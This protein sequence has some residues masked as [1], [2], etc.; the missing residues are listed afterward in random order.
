[1]CRISLTVGVLVGLTVTSSAFTTHVSGSREVTSRARLSW[2]PVPGSTTSSALAT[3]GQR[4]PTCAATMHEPRG[5]HT[6]TRLPDGRVLIVGGLTRNHAFLATAELFDPASRT[7]RPTGNMPGPRGGH[8]ATLLR[9]GQVL[10]AG[11]YTGSGVDTSALLYDPARGTFTPTGRMAVPRGGHTA[12]LLSDG[13]VLVAGGEGQREVATRSAELYDPGTGQFTATGNLT[14]T[15]AYHVA[16]PIGGSRVLIA[17][18]GPDLQHILASAEVYDERMGT[19]TPTGGMAVPRRKAGAATLA[20]GRV[21]V[22]AGA[23]TRDFRGMYASAELYDPAIGAFR[24]T[25]SLIVPRFKLSSGVVR[26][27]DGRVMVAGGGPGAEVYDPATERFTT[28]A[29]GPT[30]ARYYC[31]ATALEGGLVLL[32]GGYGDNAESD[33]HAWVVSAPAAASVAAASIGP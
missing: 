1:M 8:T 17:G 5:T 9:S 30:A 20:D 4:C 10:I 31:T 19:F 11:G 25:A 16:A 2:P 13:R 18:G 12:T 33:A 6:A 7:F 27:S 22:V 23:D 24:P 26:L 21:L 15:R 14:T 29:G 32:A 28:V 3:A